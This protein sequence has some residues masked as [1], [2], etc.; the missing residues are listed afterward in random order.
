M[1]MK[2]DLLSLRD[3]SRKEILKL[4]DDAIVLKQR[5]KANLPYF[6][7]KG[8][9]LGMLFEKPSTR[10]R[11]SF[12]AGMYQLGGNVVFMSPKE[13]Q[14]G[15]GETIEDT[16]RVLSR[17]LDLVVLRVFSHETL[18]RFA[19]NSTIPVINGL[20]DLLHPC[21]ILADILT[22]YEKTGKLEN[23]KL[24]FVGD[25]NNVA[26]SWINLATRLN[27]EVVISCPEGYEPDEKILSTALSEG[28]KVKVSHTPDEDVKDADVIY[29]DVWCS[30][31][32][33]AEREERLRK[34][35]PFQVNSKLMERCP[36]AIFM[37][38]LPA[39]RGEEVTD[40]VID[41]DRSV[42]WD[43]AENRL[44]I[45][46]AIMLFLLGINP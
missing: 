16:A 37:H 42:V 45:Q 13:T 26:N 20:S 29:T 9:V 34:F 24:V 33:E 7:L 38:C 6:P 17:Y 11:V 14:L 23:F 28:A 35:A 30:M 3:L 22:I 43:E 15:R 36:N 27:I 18:E 10:T 8:K 1:Q 21:Q 39:H 46:K 19:Q 41:G 2:R 31:G 5:H 4:I 44:H 12:E 40:D 32:Q 25:G